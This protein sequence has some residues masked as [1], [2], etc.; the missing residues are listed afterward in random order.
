[1]IGQC[2]HDDPRAR[3][4]NITSHSSSQYLQNLCFYPQLLLTLFVIVSILETAFPRRL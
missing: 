3:D 1:M 2:D 4:V